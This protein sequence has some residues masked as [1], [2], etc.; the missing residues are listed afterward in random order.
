[1]T[2]SSPLTFVW[3]FTC[4]LAASACAVDEGDLDPLGESSAELK[5]RGVQLI[6]PGAQQVLLGVTEDNFA[7]YQEGQVVYASKLER[8]ARRTH[9]ADVPG[10]NTA[11]PLQVG[12][13]MFIWSNPQQSVPGLGVSPL[14]LFTG[15]RGAQVISEQ[16]A[17]GLVAT[18]A[19]DD[20]RQILFTTRA[21]DDGQRGDLV[22]ARTR[23]PQEQTVLLENTTLGFPSAPCRPLAGFGGPAFD[24]FV[25]A[26]HCAGSDTTATLSVWRHGRRRDLVSGIRTP[27]PFFFDSDS[28]LRRMLVSLADGSLVEVEVSGDVTPIDTV[29]PTRGFVNRAD[30][31][32]YA[33]PDA[34]GT[35]AELRLALRGHLPATPI[36]PFRS[37]V[38]ETHN[39]NGYWKRS[40]MSPDNRA[41][42]YRSIVDP[43]TGNTDFLFLDLVSGE[44]T[45]LAPLAEVALT[46]Q[47]WTADSRFALFIKGI[48]PTTGSGPLLAGNQHGV[49]QIGT[50]QNVFDTLRGSGSIIS[51]QENIVFDPVVFSASRADLAVANAASPSAVPRVVTL[52]ADVNYFHSHAGRKLAFT[53]QTESAGPGLYVADA[54]P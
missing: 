5:Q 35:G 26:A 9:V 45:A 51:Y 41:V 36:G 32:G 46:S 14:V 29:P 7:V 1:M 10:T 37:F 42:A 54:I 40:P 39:R 44:S 34:A 25:I 52:Q 11:F 43:A 19:S 12:E 4:A 24:S 27:L 47:N 22:L 49:H 30:T 23:R 3:L 31:L 50:S 53:S 28:E 17:V 15:E 21:S 33:A 20:S 13:V 6:Q 16:S 2:R 48:D 8:G 18:G 38:V